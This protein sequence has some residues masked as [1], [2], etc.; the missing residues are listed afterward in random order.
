MSQVEE[1]L[2]GISFGSHLD[3]EKGEED[4][5]A[6]LLSTVPTKQ[7]RIA[8][9]RID[10]STSALDKVQQGL[11][12]RPK[13]AIIIVS[14]F[15]CLELRSKKVRQ[16]GEY[17]ASG[18]DGRVFFEVDQDLGAELMIMQ[19]VISDQINHRRRQIFV[20]ILSS[21]KGLKNAPSS[22]SSCRHHGFDRGEMRG[23]E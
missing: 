8:A 6:M 20:V 3:F 2:G 15:L 22:L 9:W 5:R 11:D 19:H 14:N 17:R 4:E 18:F 10:P 23:A 21:R 13:T 16:I 12:P 1:L 7:C